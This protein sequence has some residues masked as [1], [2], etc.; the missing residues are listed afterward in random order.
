[1]KQKNKFV[2]CLV[3]AGNT[4][5]KINL[6]KGSHKTLKRFTTFSSAM[7]YL[8]NL[9]ANIN[10]AILSSVRD[11]KSSK[12]LAECLKSISERFFTACELALSLFK[13]SYDLKKLGEDRLSALSFAL[14]RDLAPCVIV[15]AGTAVTI[16]FLNSPNLFLGGYIC[17]GF[18]TECMALSSQ[19]A[20]L[21]RLEPLLKIKKNKMP[22]NTQEAIS[23]G[24][25]KVK[26]EG[27]AALITEQLKTLHTPAKPWKIYLSGGDAQTLKNSSKLLKA[28]IIPEIVLKGLKSLADFC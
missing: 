20:L 17:A 6:I 13:S 9:K 11:S 28:E 25:I 3:D 2:Y 12:A 8:Q 22:V 19:T 24:V 26:S 23:S 21:P 27:I 18:K 10:T 14:L 15:D 1:M 5:I 7:D 4:S 16:D